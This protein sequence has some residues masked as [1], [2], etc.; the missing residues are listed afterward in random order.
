MGDRHGTG[1]KKP[2]YNTH[3]PL[4]E[5]RKSGIS[6]ASN[7]AASVAGVAELSFISQ[8][9]PSKIKYQVWGFCLFV[10]KH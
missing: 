6:P 5:R 9:N 8:T 10:F 3:G 2:D 4:L 1:G 7:W